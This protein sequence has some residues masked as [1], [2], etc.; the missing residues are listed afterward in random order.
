MFGKL[1]VIFNPLVWRNPA[2][3]QE[4]HELVVEEVVERRLDIR[5]REPRCVDGNRH[6]A[7][8]A[9]SE[10]LNLGAIYTE[11]PTATS[12]LPTRVR[13]SCLASDARRNS[14]GS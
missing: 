6:H 5:V 4:I 13:S 9:E 3:E 8:S 12:L 1:D 14:A 2:D 10:L 7:S 11:S